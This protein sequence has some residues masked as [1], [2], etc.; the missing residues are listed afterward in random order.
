[1]GTVDQRASGTTH[2][3][4]ER[5]NLRVM[6]ERARRIWVR[7]SLVIVVTVAIIV[8]ALAQRDN[9]TIRRQSRIAQQIAAEMR[10][11]YEQRRALSDL[12]LLAQQPALAEDYYFN[13]SYSIQAERRGRAGVCA[14]RRQVRLFLREDGR[15]VVLFD[16]T[17]F[18]VAWM[19]E[20]Q[21]A[22]RSA[23]LGLELALAN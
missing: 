18:T 5:A 11:A 19:S 20:A 6:H 23:E 10:E 4:A 13:P 3:A 2:Q 15:H 22:E 7:L 9:Q 12:T 17:T 1:M 14:P 8:L 16:G 21:F